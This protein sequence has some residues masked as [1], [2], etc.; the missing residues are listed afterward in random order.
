MTQHQLDCAVAAATGE[1]PATIHRFG[2]VAPA[3]LEP[4]DL[5]LSV[6]CPFCRSPASDPGSATGGLAECE[7]CDVEFDFSPA[8]VY[9]VS[10]EPRRVTG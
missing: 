3:A 5:R 1:S 4:E 9:A 10:A 6:D 7:G 2:F 8:D